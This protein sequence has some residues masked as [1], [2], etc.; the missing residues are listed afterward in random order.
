MT[1]I[2]ITLE[3]TDS[4]FTVDIDNRYKDMWQDVSSMG[5]YDGPDNFED[6]ILNFMGMN[7]DQI[8]MMIEQGCFRLHQEYTH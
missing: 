1:K 4:S 8:S 7:E 6:W 5:S 2:T 3:S